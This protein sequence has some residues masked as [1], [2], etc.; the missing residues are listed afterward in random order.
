MDGLLFETTPNGACEREETKGRRGEERRKKK[1]VF[2]GLLVAIGI[3]ATT[4]TPCFF[5][6]M[7]IAVQYFIFAY[8]GHGG[9]GQG[10]KAN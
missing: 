7:C 8:G 10:R 6:F 1:V 5:F 2:L 9:K 3:Y 4:T